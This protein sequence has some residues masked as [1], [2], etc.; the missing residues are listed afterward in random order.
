M[1]VA[2]ASAVS[3]AESSPPILNTIRKPSAFLRKLS[4]NAE[5][6][7]H[8]NSGAKRR[9]VI[10]EFDIG[11]SSRDAKLAVLERK[12]VFS[13]DPHPGPAPRSGAQR[14]PV[15]EL[16]L[17]AKRRAADQCHDGLEHRRHHCYEHRSRIEL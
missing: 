13:S 4:L 3:E 8:Q 11:D 17:G 15:R 10:R 5:K 16:F 7:W 12:I 14:A 1:K 9:D 2:P 6:N